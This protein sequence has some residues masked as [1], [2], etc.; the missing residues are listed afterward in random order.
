MGAEEQ[1]PQNGIADVTVNEAARGDAGETP[2]APPAEEPPKLEEIVTNDVLREIIKGYKPEL[3]LVSWQAK[4]GTTIGDNYMSIMY[5]VQLELQNK[6]CGEEGKETLEIMLKTIPRNAYRA[7]MIN[8]MKAFKKESNIYQNV[9]PA[10]IQL[11]KEQE[12]AKEKL[13]TPWPKCF[14][15]HVDGKTDFLAMENLKV[16][17]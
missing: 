1:T 12:F 2:A 17:G 3:E 6:G 10:F 4:P 9:F 13:F 14:A 5:S 16:A 7:D 8:E 11:Q 15:A